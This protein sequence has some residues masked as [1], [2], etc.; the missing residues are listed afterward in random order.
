MIYHMDL[1]IHVSELGQRSNMEENKITYLDSDGREVNLTNSDFELV[2]SDKKIHDVKLHGK[3]TTFFKDAMKR[4]VKSKAAVVGGVIVGMLALGAIIFPM[5]T[6]DT[7]V[8]NV[9]TNGGGAGVEAGL[10]PKLFNAGTGFW[11]GTVERTKVIY[12]TENNVPV[13]YKEDTY[14]N[15]TTYK[16]YENNVYSQYGKGGYVNVFCSNVDNPANLYSPTINFNPSNSYNLQYSLIEEEFGIYSFKGYKLS[17]FSGDQHYY[18]VGNATTYSKNLSGNFDILTQLNSNGYSLASLPATGSVYFEVALA[19]DQ[20]EIGH[21]LIEKVAISSSDEEENTQ[22]LNKISFNDGNELMLRETNPETGWLNDSG[23]SAYKVEF[24]FCN[25]RFDQYENAYG[26]YTSSYGSRQ[27]LID[28]EAGGIQLDFDNYGTNATN[29]KEILANRFKI[30]DQTKTYLAE[31]ISQEGDA[32]YNSSLKRWTGFSLTVKIW[33]YRELGYTEMPRF[34]FGTDSSSKDYF[35]LLFTGMRFSF[36]L[37]IGIS[38]VNIVIGL[39]WGSISGYFGGWTDIIMERIC[40]ILAGLPGTVIITL[41]IL[42]GREFNWG[43]SADVI[44][45]MVALFMTGWMGVSGRTRTQFY[46]FKGREYVLA[47]RTLGAKDARLIFKHILPNS[48][49]TIITGSILMIPSVI[50]TEASIAYLGLGLRNQVLFGVIL[51]E[52]NTNYAGDKAFLLFIPTFIMMLLLVSFN[53]FGNGL[54]DAF[55]PALKG[56][57]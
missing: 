30:V 36:L 53:L 28:V 6:P 19:D 55:N 21:A 26:K 50:Y 56:S 12:D 13:G 15:L 25:F 1:S 10:S 17:I 45:L 48:A 9:S 16:G 7:G 42:Y 20:A 22:T 5:F 23:K 33:K 40:D 49:G 54:R 3:A 35:K 8:F 18:L 34:I 24:T 46:R 32:V 39:V 2:Q 44:A 31:V 27:L 38:A 11:D 47:S 57:E 29:D 52:N 41:A 51:A 14:F 4:F 43:S 37:A